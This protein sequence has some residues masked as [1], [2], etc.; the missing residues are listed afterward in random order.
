MNPFDIIVILVVVLSGL[1]A[2]A[3][4]FVKE[5]LSVAAWAGAGLATLYSLPYVQPF[6]ERLLPKGMVADIAAGA[7]VFIVVLIVLSLLTSAIS[8]RVKE[9]SLSAIDRT[10][11]LLFGLV[12]G[13]VIACLLYL[14]VT[15]ALPEASR[16][17]WIRQARTVPLLASGANALRALVP[18]S[19]RTRVESTA[20][21]AQRK[22]EQAHQADEATRALLTPHSGTPA[23][24]PDSAAQKG[25]NEDQRRDLNRLFQ[26]NTQ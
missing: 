17:E 14:G 12:R 24:T 13:A 25:Y 10:L 9:S 3:R 15:W 21:E 5:A 8:R 22:V 2:F 11:G 1:F 26:Q 23:A 16:P 19:M 6:A 18:A 4:G 7:A 20:S